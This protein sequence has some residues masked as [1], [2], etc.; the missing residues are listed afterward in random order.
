MLWA[1]ALVLKYCP[2]RERA[3]LVQHGLWVIYNEV[4]GRAED[5]T[6]SSLIVYSKDMWGLILASF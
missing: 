2:R 3:D 5:L 6:V 4:S 1:K